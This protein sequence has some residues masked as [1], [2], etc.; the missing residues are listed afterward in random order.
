[1]QRKEISFFFDLLKLL[2]LSA[3]Q[4]KVFFCLEEEN[5]REVVEVYV[6]T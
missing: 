6:G 5:K 3:K 2:E 1:M 4:C